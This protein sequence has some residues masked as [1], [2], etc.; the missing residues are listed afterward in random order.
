MGYSIYLISKEKGISQKDFDTAMSNL[1]NFNQKG[2][3][4]FPP[5]DITFKKQYITV[6]GSFGLSGKYAEGFVL[7]LLMCLLDLD[8]KPKVISRDWEYGTQEDFDWLENCDKLPCY[9]CQ[10]GGCPVCC[11]SGT[12]SA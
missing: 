8:Y 4:G 7:N 3:A 1:S 2:Y 11:G 5:C 10:G 6:S 9:N 12:I